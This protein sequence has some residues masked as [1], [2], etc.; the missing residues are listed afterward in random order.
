MTHAE[1][2]AR[3]TRW[4]SG[5]TDAAAA[6]LAFLRRFLP[7]VAAD[8]GQALD[9]GA[10]IRISVDVEA[11]RLVRVRCRLLRAPEDDALNRT[12]FTWRRPADE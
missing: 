7:D 11:G 5:A 3:I 12:L 2:V 4:A 9:R 6:V 8:A 10:R 1:L